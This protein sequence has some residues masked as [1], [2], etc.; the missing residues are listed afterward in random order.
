MTELQLGS[1]LLIIVVVIGLIGGLMIGLWAGWMAWP[2]QVTNV[3]I[4]D[5]KPSSQVEYVVL[6]ASDYAF[7]QNLD[8]AK[9]RLALLHDSKIDSRIA[10][11][12]KQSATQSKPYAAQL[13]AFAVALGSTD[14][15]IALIA[16]T[17]TPTATD[18]PIPTDT[19]TPTLTPIATPTLTPT[20]TLVPTHTPTRRPRATATPQPAPVAGTNWLPSFPDGWPGGAKFVPVSVAPGQKYWHLVKALYCDQEDTRNDCPNLPG[21]GKGTSIYVM[22]ISASGART[23]SP[24][25]V[26]KTNGSRAGE[27]DIGPEKS[28]SD[29]CDCNYTWEA[30]GSTI[31]VDG[32]PSDKI[33][34]LSLYSVAYKR[35]RFHVR[36]FLTFQSVTR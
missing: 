26:I 3:D 17:A 1:R 30:D 33:S 32:A 13:A 35:D 27:D 23:S 16:T 8:R 12:A 29:M 20:A 25:I 34:G 6:I 19:S 10:G 24:L 15:E 11:L 28:A 4:S 9:Q 31:Q 14:T 5:L 36:Y 21:G 22:L 7:D 18:T 2:V